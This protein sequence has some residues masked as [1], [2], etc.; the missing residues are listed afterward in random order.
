MHECVSHE[1]DYC[2]RVYSYLFLLYILIM[3][4]NDDHSYIFTREINELPIATTLLTDRS[5]EGIES[6]IIT[7]LPPVG[8]GAD[9][10]RIVSPSNVTVT[11]IDDDC[12][13]ITFL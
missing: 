3:L 4:Q 8:T 10:V 9:N 11:I 7:L 5:G 12:K 6:F 13:K 1:D 2:T